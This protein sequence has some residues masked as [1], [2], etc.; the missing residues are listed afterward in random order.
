ME[1]GLAHDKLKEFAHVASDKVFEHE[2]RG[3]VESIKT[4]ISF[5]Q[6]EMAKISQAMQE[7]EYDI[8]VNAGTEEKVCLYLEMHSY[9]LTFLS[10]EISHVILIIVI[11]HQTFQT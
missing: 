3:P 5:I 4:S 6:A 8:S 2:D 9:S 10:L 1:Q 11:N 7:G